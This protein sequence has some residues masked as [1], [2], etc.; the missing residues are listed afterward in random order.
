MPLFKATGERATDDTKAGAEATPQ[1][2]LN[3]QSTT[4]DVKAV[5]HLL[6]KW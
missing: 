2:Q 5:T 1:L 6:Q 4:P 3:S